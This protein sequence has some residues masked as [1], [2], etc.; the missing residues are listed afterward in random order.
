MITDDILH[1]RKMSSSLIHQMQKVT[2]HLTD[3]SLDKV[4]FLLFLFSAS[5]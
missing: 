5:R 2:L 1:T 3:K 4:N